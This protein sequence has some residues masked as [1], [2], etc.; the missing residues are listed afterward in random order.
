MQGIWISSDEKICIA[1]DWKLMPFFA[2]KH[3]NVHS[4]NNIG[5][6]I[7]NSIIVPLLPFCLQGILWYQGESNAG[8]A[9]QYRQSFLLLINDWRKN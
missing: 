3:D 5:T 2:E 8:R 6:T 4:S 1:N 7:D 9:Y